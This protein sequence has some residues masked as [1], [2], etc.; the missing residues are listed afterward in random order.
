MVDADRD[1][2]LFEHAAHGEAETRVAR[3][4]HFRGRDDL[5]ENRLAGASAERFAVAERGTVA[6]DL[7]DRV[8]DTLSDEDRHALLLSDGEDYSVREVAEATGWSESKVKTRTF[9]ARR[10]LREAVERLLGR[11]PEE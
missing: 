7:A 3:R 8:L 6:A 10:R 11:L 5:V 2:H 4:R 1:Q 9:R